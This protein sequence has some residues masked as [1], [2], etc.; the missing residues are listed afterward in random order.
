MGPAQAKPKSLSLL[1]LPRLACPLQRGRRFLKAACL[2]H[3]KH[4]PDDFLQPMITG[5]R[6]LLSGPSP[7]PG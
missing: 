2:N 7:G 6:G 1:W 5:S 4:F 3:P